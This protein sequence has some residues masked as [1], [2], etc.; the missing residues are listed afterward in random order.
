[1]CMSEINVSSKYLLPLLSKGDLS[2]T[3][4]YQE[5][6]VTINECINESSPLTDVSTSAPISF[7]PGKTKQTITLLK[8]GCQ[9]TRL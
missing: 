8:Q 3:V 9:Y 1:M 7:T 4:S 5:H 2:T 6:T